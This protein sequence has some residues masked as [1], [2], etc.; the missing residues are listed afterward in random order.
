MQKQHAGAI[1]EIVQQAL[2][3]TKKKL[4]TSEFSTAM[5]SATIQ[6]AVAQQQGRTTGQASSSAAGGAD[7]RADD[8][9]EAEEQR[10]SNSST[11]RGDGSSAAT[12]RQPRGKPAKAPASRRP[13]SR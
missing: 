12:S 3:E 1:E 7:T 11:G 13:V 8:E 5:N 6:E 4:S 10:P 9:E 2:D